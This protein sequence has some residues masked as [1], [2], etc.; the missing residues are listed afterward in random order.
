MSEEQKE[1]QNTEQN[2]EVAAQPATEA[3]NPAQEATQQPENKEGDVS[4][5]SEVA[6]LAKP[7]SS[8]G[9]ESFAYTLNTPSQ[10]I[11]VKSLVEAGAHFGHQ[12][13]RWNPK[14]M[15]YLYGE[16]GGVHIINLDQTIRAWRK[17]KD[18]INNVIVKG[19][20]L[21]VVG[22]KLQ[23]REVVKAE[24]ERCGALY[25]T[26]RW[27]GGTLTNFRTLKRSLDKMI[28]LEELV[29][30]ASSEES[31]VKM[32]KKERLSIARRVTRMHEQLGGIRNM[33]KLP[34]ML[35]IIDINKESIAIAEA[36]RMGIPV[37]ALVDSNTNPECVDYPIPSNDDAART[38]RLF[39][40]ALADTVAESRKIAEANITKGYV[41]ADQGLP[42]KVKG[43]ES[44]I[45]EYV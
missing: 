11:T 38:L 2:Q 37:V 41:K 31:D 32:N 22:T 42:G 1:Q 12:V 4:A 27:L 30:E 24:S 7:R 15:P 10:D 19:G 40:G 18:A 35:F 23:A 44:M 8:H 29:V 43:S 13:D 36:K 17:A 26:T 14:M 16:R 20:Q 25:V 3:E 34:D 5:A 21:L 33:K 45:V 9:S 28:K 6:K 39:M